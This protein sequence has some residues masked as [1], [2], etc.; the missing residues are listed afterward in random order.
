MQSAF[1]SKRTFWIFLSILA[2]S[3]MILCG[4]ATF[5]YGAGVASDS[6]KY[7]SVAQNL[8][9]GKGLYDHLGMPLLAWPPLY[10]IILAGLSLLTRLDVF[11]V[12]WYFNIF[13]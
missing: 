1:L 10:S 13:L 7:L 5:K 8:L 6:T 12:G 3:G 9:A 2:M 11:I 4:I